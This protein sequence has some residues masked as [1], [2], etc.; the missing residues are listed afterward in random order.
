M[1]NSQDA[2]AQKLQNITNPAINSQAASLGR[3]GSGAFASQVNNAQTAAANE[4]AKV[5]TDLYGNQY[6]QDVA[7]QQNAAQ[8][9]GNFYNQDQQ[10]Q[11]NA[12]QA[13]AS[14]NA[15]QQQL[16]QAGTSL[17]GNLSDAQQTQRLNAANSANQQFNANRDYQ[18]QGANL[19]SNNYQNNISNMLNAANSQI[20]ADNALNTQKLNAAGMAGSTY[21]NLYNPAQALAGVGQQ[22]DQYNSTV[23][24]SKVDAW[25]QA[26]QQ[27][28]QNIA[29]FTNLLNGGGYQS[30]TQPVYSNTTGQILG[31]LSSL[32]GLFALCDIREKILHRLVGFMPLI[33]G[34]KICIYEF[35]YKDDEDANI[36]IGPVAQ[37]VE[38][39]TGA[40]VEVEG[41]KLIDVEAFMKEA[42]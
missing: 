8:Q 42:A 1:S 18:L 15:Q 35:T 40:V 38:E 21:Q 36:W 9:Y 37:E 3:M 29:N 19:L 27:P 34:E 12:N 23:L 28:L 39:K 13:L 20:S 30:T 32:A 25:N 16:R 33:N 31:G 6:N 24:Q 10:N 2:I 5:A 26:Q 11:L 41:R 22:K 17:Y 7:S 14:T 4:M